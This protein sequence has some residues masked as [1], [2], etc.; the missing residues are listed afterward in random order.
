M[1]LASG[2]AS[3]QRFRIDGAFP[4]DVTDRLVEQLS[5][6]AFGRLAALSDGT[7]VGWIG[8]GH[9]F[10]TEFEA[11][12]I[13]L[14][15]YA[16]LALRVEQNRVPPLV[17]RSYVRLEEETAL[18]ANGREFLTRAEKRQAR[19]AAEVRIEQEARSGAFRRA[20]A[21]PLLIDL[22]ARV[23]YLG[24]LSKTAGDVLI[25]LFSDTFGR[26]LDPLDAGRLAERC[27]LPAHDRALENLTP[28]RFS[29]PPGDAAD[30][31]AAWERGTHGFLGAEFLTWLWH[32]IEQ[33]D[34]RLTL[35]GG[36]EILVAMDRTLRLKCQH[37][38]TGTTTITADAPAALPEARAAGRGGKLPTRAGLVLG[39][40]VGEFRFVL[41]AERFTLSG[42]SIPEPQEAR[43]AR[44]VLEHRFDALVAA[45]SMLDALYE[46][47]L[48]ARISTHWA[49]T[50]RAMREWLDGRLALRARAGA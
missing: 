22:E 25:Q 10:Q 50:T 3:F 19:Q 21:Y 4:S 47:F 13:A 20:Q 27:L 28:T 2:P 38:L 14:G 49:A 1:G 46:L 24:S 48:R 41:D 12:Q 31:E 29:E 8:P 35:R 40:P 39:G 37:N 17:V 23:V 32:Q 36:D 7:Q 9:L 11:S 43:D 30:H 18:A 44:Q 42:M 15:R 34:Q 5:A 33:D 26:A 45:A 16:H 6:R